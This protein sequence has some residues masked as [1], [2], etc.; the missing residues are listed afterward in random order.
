MKVLFVGESCALLAVHIKGFD[1]MFLGR[2]QEN[3]DPCLEALRA[4]G[5]DVDYMK[6]DDALMHFPETV[7]E[8]KQYDAIIFSDVGS[9]TFLLHP[10]MHFGG[11]RMPNRLKLI[12]EYVAQG[13]GFLMCGGYMSFSGYEA[14]A[15]YGMTPIADILPVECLHY[16]DRMEHPD[17]IYPH[18]VDANHP[19]LKGIDSPWPYFMGYNKVLLKPE[20]HLIATIGDN[21]ED[22]FLASM[23]YKQGRS[24]V[25]SS[26]CVAH[27]GPKAF[28]EWEH[29]PTLFGNI[30]R[31]LAKEI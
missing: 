17:G 9:N 4:N 26:D 23:E 14:K 8:L 10:K 31:W 22:V 28:S 6:S 12:R 18:I 3:G 29:Y 11:E 21:N 1:H 30:V 16:D 25:F 24:A 13:G 15:R 7:E 5:F 19:I 2:C 20:A 27:W